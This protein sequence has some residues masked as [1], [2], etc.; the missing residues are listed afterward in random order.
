[1]VAN[2][3]LAIAKF[4]LKEVELFPVALLMLVACILNFIY[5]VANKSERI[6]KMYIIANITLTS[7][8]FL[9][10]II[11]MTKGL[12]E[13]GV[14]GDESRIPIYFILLGYVIIN[15]IPMII[16]ISLKDPEEPKQEE[17]KQIEE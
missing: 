1:M 15:V 17:P 2:F 10:A 11:Y 4:T 12:Y 3:V 6:R 7:L 8:T 13:K 5:F 9:Y 14:V 16:Y